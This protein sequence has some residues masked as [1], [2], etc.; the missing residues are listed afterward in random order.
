VSNTSISGLHVKDFDHPDQ[1]PPM[2]E[3]AR[4]ELIEVGGLKVWRFT[5]EPGWRYTLHADTELCT[6]PHVA[7]IAAGRLAIAMEDGTQM[8]AGPGSVVTIG[9]GHDAWTVGDEP[10][11]FVDFGEAITGPDGEA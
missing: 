11:R 2:G 6:A 7:F 5:F 8:E 9:P 1:A 4:G 3:K 10:C